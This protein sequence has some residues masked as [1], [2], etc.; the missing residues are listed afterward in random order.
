MKMTMEEFVSRLLETARVESMNWRTRADLMRLLSVR[1]GNVA[2]ADTNLRLSSLRDQLA[3]VTPSQ[4]PR[5]LLSA[6]E[7]YRLVE[8]VP[9]GK[10]RIAL[11]LGLD[12][13]LRASEVVSLCWNDVSLDS[14]SLILKG[15]RKIPMTA[16]LRA[17]M[18]EGHKGS[19]PVICND[20][21]RRITPAFLRNF[22]QR[23]GRW[24]G[25][26]RLSW[27]DLRRWSL[28]GRSK[29]EQLN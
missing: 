15:N 7:A 12:A 11:L 2:L 22:V 13:G 28:E 17:A 26:Q 16:R 6:Q 4:R 19:G 5:R 24:L 29:N 18:E 14:G 9:S 23:A 25:L 27:H 20:L 1:V 8:G 10:E 3:A 21:G